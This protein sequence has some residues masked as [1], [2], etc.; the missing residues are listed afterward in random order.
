MAADLHIHVLTDKFTEEHCK[1]FSSNVLGSKWFGYRNASIG[2]RFDL[3]GPASDTPNVWVGEVSWLKA[4][5]LDDADK[6][7]PAAVEAIAELIGDDFPVIDDEMISA[8]HAAFEAENGTSYSVSEG[9]DVI[10]FLNEHKGKKAF[11][12]SW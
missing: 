8:V 11:T 12:V 5:L 6:Y 1:V 3:F 10:D 7:V 2:N 9:N 4:A